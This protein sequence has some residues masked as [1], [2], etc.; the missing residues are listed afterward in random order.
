MKPLRILLFSEGENRFSISAIIRVFMTNMRTTVTVPATSANLGPGFDTLGMA[1]SLHNR[2]TI[3]EIDGENQITVRGHGDGLLPN[4]ETNL[5]YC[6]A[7]RVFRA[8]G[9]RPV[10]IRIDIENRIPVESGL[11]SSSTAIV[12]GMM[13]ANVLAGSPMSQLDLLDFA[14][15]MEGHPDNVTPAIFGG[16][17]VSAVHQGQAI[18]YPLNLAQPFKVAI[19]LP[20]YRLN[21]KEA[22]AALPS[23]IPFKDAVFNVSRIALL[24]RALETGDYEMLAVAMNDQLHQPYRFKL[25]PGLEYACHAVRNA[26]AAGVAISGSGPGIVIFSPDNHDALIRTAS[27]S[28][29]QAGLTCQSWI[30]DLDT[31]GATVEMTVAG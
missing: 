2:F 22:R 3:T 4:D 1:V 7:E 16:I 9:Y 26:G 10:G 19:V 11:G 8:V 30:L 23:M 28:F 17:T 6:A 20:Q 29:G 21:T 27:L 18:H 15:E 14:N 12:G 31:K 24:I 25:V 5:V 13:A